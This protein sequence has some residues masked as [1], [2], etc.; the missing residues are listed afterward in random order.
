MKLSK[1]GIKKLAKW[2]KLNPR[3]IQCLL[4]VLFFSRGG[5]RSLGVVY[6]KGWQKGNLCW[7][8]DL[9]HEL[10]RYMGLKHKQIVRYLSILHDKGWIAVKDGQ[11]KLSSIQFL[12]PKYG[13]KFFCVDILGKGKKGYSI[14]HWLEF[15][16]NRQS[17]SKEKIKFKM[18]DR[19]RLNRKRKHLDIMS[20]KN[21][22]PQAINKTVSS[23]E[24]KGTT[25]DRAGKTPKKNYIPFKPPP[26]SGKS[27][28]VEVHFEK[29]FAA[30]DHQKVCFGL[31]V[32]CR[33]VFYKNRLYEW[34]QV[35]LRYELVKGIEPGKKQ[36]KN[37]ESPDDCWIPGWNPALQKK[38]SR[39]ELVQTQLERDKQMG[40][41][42][43]KNY[44]RPT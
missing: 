38:F 16:F 25:L 17:H 10:S 13:E 12:L 42:K 33:A 3:L 26:D 18:S 43:Y 29:V 44:V 22:T 37:K 24:K 34:H 36:W 35:Y 6:R 19:T 32:D 11:Y 5:K 40:R 2:E 9:K 7:N 20:R 23:I 8:I 4:Y 21:K 15:E 39:R 31:P 14:F 27:G 1:R 41:D 30:S 28:T